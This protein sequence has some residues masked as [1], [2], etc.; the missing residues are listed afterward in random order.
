MNE[1]QLYVK[2]GQKIRQIRELKK[3]TQQELAALCNIEKSNM[4]RIEAGRSN[5][6]LKTMLIISDSLS[7]EIK[8]LLDF[9]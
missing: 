6:T 4:S 1:N 8:D 3:I 9:D 2:V 5:L 7:I